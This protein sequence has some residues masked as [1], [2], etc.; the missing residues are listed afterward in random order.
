LNI[1]SIYDNTPFHSMGLMK[2]VSPAPPS[3]DDPATVTDC[4]YGEIKAMIVNAADIKILSFTS[5]K[6]TGMNSIKFL[7]IMCSHSL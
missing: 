4:Q 7:P 5:K 3:A 2:V 1:V 6:H